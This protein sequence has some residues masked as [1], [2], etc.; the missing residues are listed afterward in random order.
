MAQGKDVRY[1]KMEMRNTAYNQHW[2]VDLMRACP[3]QP[4]CKLVCTLCTNLPD[5]EQRAK[6]PHRVLCL[7]LR[8]LLLGSVV[9]LLRVLPPPQARAVQRHEQVR[10]GLGRT[11]SG[12]SDA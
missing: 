4:G 2:K 8:S 10:A 6:L 3:K 5:V 1:S 12:N 11:E 9:R 7:A